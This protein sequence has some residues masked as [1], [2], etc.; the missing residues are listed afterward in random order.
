VS[1]FIV[2]LAIIL[3]TVASAQES[4]PISKPF[5]NKDGEIIG[6]ATTSLNVTYLR[7][8]DGELLATITFERDK[9]ILRDPSGNILDTKS[10][11]RGNKK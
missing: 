3:T 2:A 9:V 7:D 8:L 4:L 11:Q 10:F 1:I 5:R 6:T